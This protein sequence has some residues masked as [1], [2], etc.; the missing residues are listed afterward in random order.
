MQSSPSGYRATRHW[1]KTLCGQTVPTRTS[2]ACLDTIRPGKLHALQARPKVCGP[3]ILFNGCMCLQDQLTVYKSITIVLQSDELQS[4][5]IAHLIKFG[6]NTGKHA[7]GKLK[8]T[9]KIL[10]WY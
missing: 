4:T 2:H 10:D 6:N 7:I 8:Q 5:K 3:F 9:I 1:D